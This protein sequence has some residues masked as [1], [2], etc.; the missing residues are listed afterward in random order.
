MCA[1]VPLSVNYRTVL[2]PHILRELSRVR[3]RG[4]LRY[5]S[6]R[7]AHLLHLGF[8]HLMQD[9]V[10]SPQSGAYLTLRPG[11]SEEHLRADCALIP[12]WD[13]G[14]RALSLHDLCH[15]PH[16]VLHGVS[17]IGVRH[18]VINN[19]AYTHDVTTNPTLS[20][21]YLLLLPLVSFARG[22]LEGGLL[23][24]DRLNELCSAYPP[25]MRV[26]EDLPF[27]SFALYTVAA[28]GRTKTHV[29]P[30]VP[31]FSNILIT[32]AED[33][34]VH[35]L[36]ILSALRG[37]AADS[38]GKH[39]Q[40][41]KQAQLIAKLIDDGHIASSDCEWLV[42]PNNSIASFHAGVLVHQ[43]VELDDNGV[44]VDVLSDNELLLHGKAR[45]SMIGYPVAN[46]FKEVTL[47]LRRL[48][49]AVPSSVCPGD[50]SSALVDVHQP[51]IVRTKAMRRLLQLHGLWPKWNATSKRATQLQHSPATCARAMSAERQRFLN[52]ES[53]SSVCLPTMPSQLDHR[54][55]GDPP[56]YCLLRPL[57]APCNTHWR[58]WSCG[59]LQLVHVGGFHGHA[60][61]FKQSTDFDC[62]SAPLALQKQQHT[63]RTKS[64]VQHN[65]L[66][67]SLI[68]RS[69][70]NGILTSMSV[71][72]RRNEARS[73]ATDVLI[74]LMVRH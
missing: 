17:E 69:R 57:V 8:G 72:E 54:R 45:F 39:P 73:L 67:T 25:H 10:Y 37:T 52:S 64:A 14:E 31:Q 5:N 12:S 18:V 62:A 32:M 23:S 38:H 51:L 49:T 71:G 58:W 56:R 27:P 35:H 42:V 66:T 40:S 65:S 34:C 9:N 50:G 44:L 60:S 41:V 53:A 48:Q 61:G 3:N 1:H 24:V 19:M 29:D 59:T 55:P 70:L 20:R 4:L 33:G 46:C 11:V 7:E 16:A 22:V 6:E 43:V 74:S 15:I 36:R 26:F 63:Q 47:G 30:D 68:T 28:G 2:L 21:L 13:G